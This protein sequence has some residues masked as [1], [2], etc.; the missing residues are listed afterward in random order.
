MIFKLQQYFSQQCFCLLNIDI[1]K[2]DAILVDFS[3]DS[4]EVSFPNSFHYFWLKV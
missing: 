2:R 1:Q 3:S 4:Y